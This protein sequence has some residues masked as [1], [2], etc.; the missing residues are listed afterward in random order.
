MKRNDNV[1]L[2]HTVYTK[3]ETANPLDNFAVAVL[4]NDVVGHLPK[5]DAKTISFFLQSDAR[6][7]C[8]VV[9]TDKAVNLGDKKGMQVPCNLC[10]CGTCPFLQRLRRWLSMML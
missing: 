1:I 2:A 7:V 3:A 4:L 6:N 5:G 10:S 8:I 9:V